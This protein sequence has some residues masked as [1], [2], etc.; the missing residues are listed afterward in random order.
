[1]LQFTVHSD[2]DPD[3]ASVRRLLEA[4]LTYA[5]MSAAKTFLL[6]LLAV[7]SMAV[8]VGAMW[9]AV[10]PP[11]VLEAALALWVALL[12]FAVL[13]SVEEWLWHR[14]VA[15]YQSER[16]AKQKPAS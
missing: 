16:Q 13:A 9:P 3:R 6:H 11:G 5:R 4:H 15:R 7:V 8:W 1:M 10:L 14:R 2:L 12:F